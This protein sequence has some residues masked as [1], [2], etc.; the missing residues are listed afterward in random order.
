MAAHIDKLK[1]FLQQKS[2]LC[3]QLDQTNRQMQEQLTE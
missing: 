3:T 2:E 1:D